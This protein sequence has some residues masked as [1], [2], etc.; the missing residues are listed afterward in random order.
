MDGAPILESTSGLATRPVQ[1][2]KTSNSLSSK[3][4][5]E[6]ARM[7][8]FEEENMTRL[9]TTKREAKRRREDEEALA[10]GYGVG[11]ASRSRGRRQ[12][13][14]EAELEGV[15]GERSSKKL[16]EGVSQSLGKRGTVLDRARSTN[17]PVGEAGGKSKKARFEK[18]VKGNSRRSGRA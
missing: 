6:L 10:M 9:V 14:L 17:R 13:G 15:L 2:D 1:L 12:N 16:W 5:A 11:G 4:A 3:R 8:Q 18:D 7:D